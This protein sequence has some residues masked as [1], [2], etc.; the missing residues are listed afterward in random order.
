VPGYVL[1][2]AVERVMGD[3]VEND[4]ERATPSCIII[5]VWQS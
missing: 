4:E 2:M 1:E 3:F 5:T